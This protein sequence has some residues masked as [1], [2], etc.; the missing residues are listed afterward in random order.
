M[1]SFLDE[2]LDLGESY[3][4]YNFSWVVENQLAAMAW[5]ETEGNL[6][7]L[8]QNGIKHVVTLSP[9]KVPPI[10]NSKLE[11][12]LIPVEEF[13]P[14]TLD[15][16]ITFINICETSLA[17][18]ESVGVHCRMGRGR[19]GVMAAC[20]LV[21]FLGLRPETAVYNL[22]CWRPGS[23]E[24]YGQER[25]VVEYHDYLRGTKTSAS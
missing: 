13:E 11:W 7:F 4:P 21:H 18:K 15:N 22:R 17:K 1:T 6:N 14:P 10:A 3:A 8:W 12:T 9:E 24:T 20:F 25:A 19:T 23:V 5:P 16:M 2:F